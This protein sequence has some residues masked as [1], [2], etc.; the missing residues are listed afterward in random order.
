MSTQ[1][2]IENII[3][4]FN[5]EKVHNTMLALNWKWATYNSGTEVPS[6]GALVVTAQN[7]LHDAC[8]YALKNKSDAKIATGG[9]HAKAFYCKET[10]QIDNLELYFQITSWDVDLNEDDESYF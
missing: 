7:L 9:F 4:N 10:N 3:E 5:W 6:I 2:A 1:S 8:F